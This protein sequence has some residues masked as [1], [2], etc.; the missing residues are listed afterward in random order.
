MAAGLPSG[1]A[2]VESIP[3]GARVR[4]SR[5][6]YVPATLERTAAL[7]VRELKQAAAGLHANPERAEWLRRGRRSRG[8]IERAQDT[9]RGW[10]RD[11]GIVRP[12]FEIETSAPRI[13]EI[14]MG[15]PRVSR[16][17]VNAV[18]RHPEVDGLSR[19]ELATWIAAPHAEGTSAT[20]RR[21][22]PVEA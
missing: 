18:R 2:T 15:N 22:I 21:G 7:A 19:E 9:V 3:G 6:F 4:F 14:V 5:E 16:K 10:L 12:H 13:P 20:E 17:T 8:A 11:S 1:L